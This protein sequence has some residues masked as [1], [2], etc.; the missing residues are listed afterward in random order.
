ML[1]CAVDRVNVLVEDVA[2]RADQ[3]R[4]DVRG[5]VQGTHVEVEVRAVARLAQTLPQCR[6]TVVRTLNLAANGERFEREK[7]PVEVLVDVDDVRLA[8]HDA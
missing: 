8:A 3:V 1:L 5:P 6:E 2:F 7:D 4:F